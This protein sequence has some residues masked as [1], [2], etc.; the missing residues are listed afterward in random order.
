MDKE[1]LLV[2]RERI[3]RSREQNDRIKTLFPRGVAPSLRA[4][5][6]RCAVDL[7]IEHHSGLIRVAEAGEYGTAAALLRPLLESSTAAFWFMYV[8]TCAEIRGLP[9]TTVENAST[10]IPMLGD[11]A[12]LLVP[13]FSPVQ[14]IVDELK[15]GGRAKWLHKYTHGGTPQ[16]IRRGPGWTEAEVMLTLIRGD[17]FSV[18]GACLETVIAPN[19]A[20]SVYAFGRR[21]E[22]AEEMSELFGVSQIAQQPHSLPP[23]QTDGCG[24]P[25]DIS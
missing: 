3:T 2:I 24:P 8:A 17:L 12:R 10:D 7:A 9:T 22:L 19:H 16:L 18:L 6:A 15:K 23:A 14:T 5:F 25:F 21:D 13:I 11:M 1:S 20:L 4:N